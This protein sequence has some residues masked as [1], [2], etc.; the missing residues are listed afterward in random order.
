[1]KRNIPRNIKIY[2]ITRVFVALRFIIPIWVT[3]FLRIITFEQ[4]AI[5]EVVAL[6]ISTLFELPSG[7]LADLIGRRWTIAIGLVIQ[8]AGYALQSQ[9][10]NFG[11]YIIFYSICSICLP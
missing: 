2:Y 9:S 6:V 8:G 5:G 10:A 7:A 3:F 4:M 1:M 11:Q